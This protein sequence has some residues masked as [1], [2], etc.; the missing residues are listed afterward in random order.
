MYK[1]YQGNVVPPK[2]SYA[3][4]PIKVINS[5]FAIHLFFDV[6]AVFISYYI[7]GV[8]RFDVMAS[9]SHYEA[10][11]LSK[12]VSYCIVISGVLFLLYSFWGMYDG[13]KK[14]HR[15]P[16]LR[17]A[18]ICNAIMIGLVAICLYYTKKNWHMRSFFTM[19]FI[20]NIFV[21]FILRYIINKIIVRIR[22]KTKRFTFSCLLV[23]EGEKAKRF[24][25]RLT[26]DTKKCL[27]RIVERMP[28]PKTAED[29]DLIKEK[30]SA[31][32]LCCVIYI[33]ENIINDN[34]VRIIRLCTDLNVGL[35]VLAPQF[36]TFHNPFAFGD[37][38][39][40]IPLVHFS[41]HYFS[42]S[43]KKIRSAFSRAL[44]VACVI[45]ASPLLLFGYL[46]VK[47]S[48]KGPALFVQ[49]RCGYNCKPFK[50]YKFRTMY[51]GADKHVEQLRDKNESDG[52]LFKLKNDPRIF[53]VGHF[54]RKFSIDELPQLFNVIKGDM[55]LVGPRPLPMT[56][57]K[58]FVSDWHY[59][60]HV[61]VPG[62]TCIWQVSGRSNIKFEEM[63]M[64]DIW[65]ALN[66]NVIMDAKLIFLT[67]STVLFDKGAY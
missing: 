6:L 62:L 29:W 36:L 16:I 44:G 41:S 17:T 37:Y 38:I 59:L 33:D 13:Y 61:S 18:V 51:V 1:K 47:L 56:D 8:L 30:V 57:L 58:Y 26:Y 10:F 60:R 25:E 19:V 55:R 21:T 42:N 39:D 66:K 40:G 53:P 23:G 65:Y 34:L 46:A 43:F 52:G 31:Q 15:T 9:A 49:E 7:A 4:N 48:S 45:I 28:T 2:T 11:Y 5:I 27:Y 24:D 64:L 35:K 54:L 22:K 50:M 32:S 63:C 3:Q 14:I 20:V 12:Y 67:I